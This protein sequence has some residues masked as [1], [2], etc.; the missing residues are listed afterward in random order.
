[1]NTPSFAMHAS[2]NSVFKQVVSMAIFAAAV[3]KA[4]NVDSLNISNVLAGE[5][6]LFVV[7]KLPDGRST[8]LPV[9]KKATAGDSVANMYVGETMDGSW[10]VCTT[11]GSN[12]GTTF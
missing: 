7:V 9:S 3:K 12:G 8:S 11:A 2:D 4:E 1:M 10:V 6:G 5:N